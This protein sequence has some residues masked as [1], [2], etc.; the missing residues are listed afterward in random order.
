MVAGA[1]VP[2]LEVEIQARSATAR[3]AV[4][5]GIKGQGTV[6]SRRSCSSLSRRRG[7]K[8]FFAMPLAELITLLVDNEADFMYPQTEIIS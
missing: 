3:Y 5:A 2:A 4:V 6:G 8:L 7:I 1:T